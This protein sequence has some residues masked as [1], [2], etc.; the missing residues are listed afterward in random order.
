MNLLRTI[1]KLFLLID[2]KERPQF[3]LLM[4]ITI[5]S[6]IIDVVGVGSILPFFSLLLDN[7]KLEDNLVLRRAYAYGEFSDIRSFQ[8]F[9]GFC[10]LSIFIFGAGLRALMTRLQIKFVVVREHLLSARLVRLY[11]NQPY[12][13]FLNKRS[14]NLGQSILS[15]VEHICVHGFLPMVQFISNLVLMVFVLI[16]LV[17]VNFK[18]TL[19]SGLIIGSSYFIIYSLV[20]DFLVKIGEKRTQA[21]QARFKFVSEA[22]GGIKTIKALCL[23]NNYRLLFFKASENYTQ[24]HL[25]AQTIAKLP[26]FFLEAIVFGGMMIILL[27]HINSGQNIDIIIPELALFAF[28]GYRIM[29]AA[30]QLY[31]TSA[32][33]RFIHL[34]INDLYQNIDDIKRTNNRKISAPKTRMLKKHLV[35]KDVSYKYPGV[36]Q[37]A[38][39]K[40]NLEISA[41]SIVGFVG[42][43]G[44]GKTT[45]ADVIMGLLSPQSG[46]IFLDGK[47]INGPRNSS[48]NQ[49]IGYVPQE[50]FLLDASIEE[51]ITLQENSSNVDFERLEKV[52]KYAGIS[53][54]INEK[55]EKGYKTIVG[56]RGSRLSGG[57]R[58][59]V[60]IARA[61][62]QNPTILILDEATSSLDGGTEAKIMHSILNANE[63]ITII[64]IAHR[65]H[66]LE[67]CEKIHVFENGR[68]VETGTL[69]QLKIDSNA[70]RNM[71][72]IIK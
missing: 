7:A 56:E 53:D 38:L 43:S 1:R 54:F 48:S 72:G 55:L 4:S 2:K 63:D 40:I 22:F 3:F 25:S 71:A 19:I 34:S 6:A 52:A 26:R 66:T 13:W 51:N 58:Q 9:L 37:Q 33:L 24:K 70:F 8:F 5:T 46:K 23:E 36:D 11:L 16:L 39:E 69:S 57:Q 35:L 47:I 68:L 10:L 45:L 44:S 12:E 21:N 17:F 31:N 67:K 29:P 62:Y 50:I 64:L 49:V 30:Q 32:N 14:A 28:A 18:V 60:G 15:E 42:A 20:K 59:R 27:L 61:L 65:I 41:K